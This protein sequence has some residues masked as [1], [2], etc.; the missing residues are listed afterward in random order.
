MSKRGGNPNAQRSSYS[1]CTLQFTWSWKKK[2]LQ[3][4]CTLDPRETTHHQTPVPRKKWVQKWHINMHHGMCW[5]TKRIKIKRTIGDCK[6][7]W[8]KMREELRGKEMLH[9][10]LNIMGV[11]RVHQDICK[12][13]GHGRREAR[14]TR[15]DI[16]IQPWNGLYAH[17]AEKCRIKCNRSGRTL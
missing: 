10:E 14:T 11:H 5:V 1:T 2:M 15:T 4:P 7:H 13:K 8:G 6:K 3:H 9:N 16:A 17:K 12:Q